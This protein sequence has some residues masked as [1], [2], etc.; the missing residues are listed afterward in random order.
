MRRCKRCKSVSA[1]PVDTTREGQQ[2]YEL[3]AVENSFICFILESDVY[4]KCTTTVKK[5]KSLTLQF[6]DT[7]TYINQIIKYIGQ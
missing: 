3:N 4:N 6:K 1:A 7:I 2:I 5:K